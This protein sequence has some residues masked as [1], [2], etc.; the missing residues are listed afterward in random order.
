MAIGAVDAQPVG[1]LHHQ[2][3]D[4]LGIIAVMLRA[5]RHIRMHERMLRLLRLPDALAFQQ[6]HAVRAGG[7]EF[8][9]GLV[10]RSGGQYFA[11]Q[12]TGDIEK[13]VMAHEKTAGYLDGRTPKKVIVVPGKIVNIVG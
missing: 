9:N 13:A 7:E 3:V 6:E 12:N 10:S 1:H 8:A 11:I 2:D 4:L 5:F